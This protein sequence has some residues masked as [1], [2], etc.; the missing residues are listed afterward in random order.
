MAIN[1]LSLLKPGFKTALVEALFNEIVSNSNTYY[2][3]IGK[4]LE[5]AGGSDTLSAPQASAEYEAN[6][7]E[8]MIFL[9]KI[10]PADISYVVPRYDWVSGTVFDMYDDCLG[11]QVTTA[12]TASGTF[13]LSGTFDQTQIGVGYVVSGTNIATG[14]LVT[15]V[16]AN[17]VTVD[18]ALEGAVTSA[19]FS[20]VAYSGATSLD[21][22]KFYCLTSDRNVY[23]CL[24]NNNNAPS[25][26][27]PYAT[28]HETITTD[29][30]YVWKFM[31][32]VP[33]SLVNKFVT[34]DDVPVT[35]AVKNPYYSSGAL[36]SV[37]V[38]VRG[39]DY[40]PGDVL[41]V[42]G[43]GYLAENPVRVVTLIIDNA[44]SGYSSA[45]TLTIGAPFD[46]VAYATSTSYLTNQYVHVGRY[47]YLV[48][49]GGTSGIS[50]P[51]HT[52]SE[53][54]VNGTCALKFVGYKAAGTATISGTSVNAVSMAGMV[55][56][57]NIDAVGSGYDPL[58]PPAVTIT[59]DGTNATAVADVSGAGYITK[60]TLT[61]RGSGYTTATVSIDPP[62]S[63]IAAVAS[64]E[65][66]YGFGY[67][68][69]PI[70]TAS[71]PFTA[72][73]V[74]APLATAA[75]GDIVQASNRFYEVMSSGSSQSLGSTAPI[76]TTGTVT[77]GAASLKFVGQTATLSMFVEQTK[78][79]LAPVIE[80]GQITGV[81]VVDPG[82]GYTTA[83]VTAYG[84]G[85]DA[86][87]TPNLSYGDLNTRQA[88][89][90]LLAVPGTIDHIAILSPG[91]NYSYATVQV[92]GDG[93][94]CTAE[95]TINQGVITAI[96]V[97]DPGVGYT[98]AT[99]TIT[100]NAEAT[101]AYARAIVSPPEGHGKNAVRELFASDLSLSSTVAKDRNQGFEVAN[102]YRQLG[103]IKNPRVFGSTLLYNEFSG[104]ACFVITGDFSYATINTSSETTLTDSNGKTY[105]VVAKPATDPGASVALLVQSMDN[106]T[107]TVG[108][109]MTYN[110]TNEATLTA[111][112]NPSV[113]KYSGDIL[114]ID[115]RSAFM[116]TDEQTVSIKTAIRL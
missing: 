48:S 11:K 50:A 95:A 63:G 46:S 87:L 55:G 18:T 2:Y 39:S 116:P 51:T 67:S 111:V 36:R 102:D 16:T 68:G 12:C 52:S 114:F 81:I 88:N 109:T 17:T 99:V 27:K 106:A 85:Q 54:I 14:T 84:F 74:W 100:G 23:K 10:T 89:I 80:A 1:S 38:D 59:G 3:F 96:T 105:K 31:Y 21:E 97:T 40:E 101:Q 26:S 64:A 70:V 42:T 75:L 47:V 61:N 79:K 107:P 62:V 8:E 113:N 35:L 73:V 34:V 110:S 30:G 20:N 72:D 28:T 15:S 25:T 83:S 19:T 115:N 41:I 33:N 53:P 60:I 78:A 29:D 58:N 92:T 93:T 7:R 43:D 44:G 76:H 13:T 104:S 71:D 45:P 6:T 49:Q 91:L 112:T 108:Q 24:S 56:Y 86:I 32:S 77:V 9:K 4:T 90:E 82:V 98:Q 37:T 57:I 5:W 66:Y 94:G 22:A 103:I 65:I 69:A